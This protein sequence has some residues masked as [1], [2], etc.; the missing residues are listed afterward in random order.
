MGRKFNTERHMYAGRHARDYVANKRAAGA[1][2]RQ[3]QMFNSN[4]LSPEEKA[5]LEARQR[6]EAKEKA[7]QEFRRRVEEAY[8]EVAAS[9]GADVEETPEVEETPVVEVMILLSET[10]IVELLLIVPDD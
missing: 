4:K 8:G 5:A 6:K 3:W 9:E 2:N 7:A 10:D 1:Q